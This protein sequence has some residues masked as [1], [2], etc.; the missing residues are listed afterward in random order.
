MTQPRPKPELPPDARGQSVTWRA[1]IIGALMSV[2]V[3]LVAGYTEM[4]V[5]STSLAND[6]TAAAALYVLAALIALVHFPLYFIARRFSLTAAELVTAYV[7]MLVSCGL[8]TRG[9]VEFLGPNI[10]SAQY[11]ADDINRWGQYFVPLLQ[12]LSWVTVNEADVVRAYYDGLPPGASVPWAP[13]ILPGLMWL[14]FAL[15]MSLGMV[16]VVVILRRQWMDN[17]RLVYPMMQVP[18]DIVRSST[19]Q[20]AG[21]N[22]WKSKAM[23]IGFAIPAVLFT[24]RALGHQDYLPGIFPRLSLG[25]NAKII[26]GILTLRLRFSPICLGFMYFVR[27]DVLMGLWVF[28]LVISVFFRSLRFMGAKPIMPKIGIWSYDTIKAFAGMGALIVF[29]AFILYRSRRHVK[30]AFNGIWRRGESDASKQEIM[31]Y[32]AAFILLFVCGAFMFGWLVLTGLAWWQAAAFLVLCL[33]IFAALT[34]VIAEAGLPLAMTP[35]CAGDF[36]VG[37]FGTGAFT[38]Q[39]LVGMGLT[40]PYHSEMRTSVMALCANG[41]KLFHETVFHNRRRMIWGIVAAVTLSYVASMALMIYFPYERGGLNLDRFSFDSSAKYPWRDAA[42]RIEKP[43]GPIWAA[44]PW[45]MGGAA[46]MALL[47]AASHFILSWPIHPIGLIVCFNWGGSILFSSA[48]V[49]WMVKGLLLKYGGPW[50]F[51]AARPFFVGMVLGQ[52]TTAGV[53]ATIDVFTGARGNGLM[54]MF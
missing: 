45:M 46:T 54:S 21:K 7:M 9:L 47:L 24:L 41:L 2:L 27:M 32:R 35:A 36:M 19:G 8:P 25:T 12:D 51:R 33:L 50:L 14:A 40:Y 26:E 20:A 42:R 5:K 6:F 37:L 4:I 1:L 39:N 18:L 11:Y 34:R 43:H 23:W 29:M 16:C 53:W 49:M 13:W 17:E 3:G 44:Y 52:V 38:R 15:A 28:S 31:S 30:A 22:V 10:T 48:I